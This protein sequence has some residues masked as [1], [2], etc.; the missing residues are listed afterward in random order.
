MDRGLRKCLAQPEMNDEAPND[1]WPHH[2][3]HVSMKSEGGG[4]SSA[5]IL[6]TNQAN[7]LLSLASREGIV[8]ALDPN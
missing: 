1:V 7:N 2:R 3:G 5:F 6:P 4:G 8:K